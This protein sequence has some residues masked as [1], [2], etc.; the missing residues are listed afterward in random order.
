[1]KVRS[2]RKS[3]TKFIVYTVCVFGFIV[4]LGF[5][6]PKVFSVVSSIAMTPVHGLSNWYQTSSDI[7]PSVL[8]DRSDLLGKIKGLENE[9]VISKG[10]EL[11]LSRLQEENIRLRSLLG[12]TKEERILAVVTARPDELPYD[13]LQIDQGSKSG[14]TKGAPVYVGSDRIIG[15]V[16]HVSSEYSFVRLFSNPG[17]EMTGFIAGPN[18]IATVEGVGGGVARVRVPQGIPLSIGNLVHVPS[19]ASGIFGQI[20]HV[21]NRPSQP[22][23]YGY[24]SLD[25]AIQSL[26]EVSVAKNPVQEPTLEEINRA[27]DALIESQLLVERA[28][29]VSFEQATSTGTTTQQEIEI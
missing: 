20:D 9:L 24:I 13:L 4:L 23:Q 1:M 19:V 8:R 27:V 14:I 10:E 6:M 5:L 22:E 11:T 21:E 12:A 18:V 16:T 3:R 7:L 17:F 2:S 28:N 29:T 25:V 15:V 26:H